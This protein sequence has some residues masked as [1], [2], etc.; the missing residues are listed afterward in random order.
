MERRGR[1]AG[2][3]VDQCL[4]TASCVEPVKDGTTDEPGDEAL[5]KLLVRQDRIEASRERLERRKTG[6]QMRRED[7]S[8]A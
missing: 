1:A 8:A 2:R 3:R 7:G 5:G 6:P 4:P